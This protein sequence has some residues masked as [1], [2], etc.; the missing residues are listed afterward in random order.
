MTSKKAMLSL[1]VWT[2]VVT[3][4]GGCDLF[5]KRIEQPR[6]YASPYPAPK[7]WA[8]APFRNESGTSIVDP[9]R[10]A[11]HVTQQIQQTPGITIVPVNRVIAAMDAMDMTAVTSLDTAMKLMGALQVDGLL[12]GTITAWDPYEPPK[13][14]AI[15][16][17]YARQLPGGGTAL[18][19]RQLTLAGTDPALPG[20]TA[21]RQPIATASGHFDA[22][23]G[24]VLQRLTNYARGRAPDD[25]AAG[26]RRYLINMDLYSEFVSH[27]LMRRLFAAE[28]ERLHAGVKPE[29]ANT[30]SDRPN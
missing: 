22:A 3:T 9:A 20:L 23:N 19:S 13:I 8:V 11:D 26:W 1:A 17:L 4:L 10:F 24:A 25:S 14:G 5:P 12:V 30:G 15:M 7:L 2:L 16:Q 29:S 27:E 28:W 6:Q 21:Y 18:D